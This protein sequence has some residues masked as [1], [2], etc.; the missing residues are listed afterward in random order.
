[1]GVEFGCWCW[2]L[3]GRRWLLAVAIGDDSRWPF[4]VGVGFGCWCWVLSGRRSLVVVLW[5]VVCVD[6]GR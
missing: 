2:V 4:C 5:V 3:N 1:M 6:V